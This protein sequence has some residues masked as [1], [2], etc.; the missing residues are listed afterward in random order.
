MTI[1][2]FFSDVK[3]VFAG[4][5]PLAASENENEPT[6]EVSRH[7]KVTVST[8]G[9]VSVLGGKW[10]TYRKIGEDLINSAEI[11]GGLR[12]QKVKPKSLKF[13][14]IRQK[15]TLMTHFMFMDRIKIRF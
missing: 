4:L 9:L 15:R 11:V 6:K 7:H 2:L 10:T 3:S 14:D 8:S 13:M 5:R 1:F 12:K